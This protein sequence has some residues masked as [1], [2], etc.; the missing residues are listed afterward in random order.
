LNRF[1]DNDQKFKTLA[2]ATQTD[3]KGFKSLVVADTLTAKH[4]CA[5]CTCIN[6]EKS[7]VNKGV[8]CVAL[9]RKAPILHVSKH[10]YFQK[11][12]LSFHA[13]EA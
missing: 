6:H 4:V 12:S 11:I 9:T 1:F 7:R 3:E 2:K 5:F 8:I 10:R 13:G